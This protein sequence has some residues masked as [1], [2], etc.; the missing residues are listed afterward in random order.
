[1]L[2]TSHPCGREDSDWPNG[3]G[4]VHPQDKKEGLDKL[5]LASLTRESM[6]SLEYPS[7]SIRSNTLILTYII[8]I[9]NPFQYP[10]L[11]FLMNWPLGFWKCLPSQAETI[12]FRDLGSNKARWQQARL[13]TLHSRPHGKHPEIHN[14][15]LF[16]TFTF[17]NGNSVRS[18]AGFLVPSGKT[19]N[20]V[21]FALKD[22]HSVQL[23][24]IL[25]NCTTLISPVQGT[26]AARQEIGIYWW[27]AGHN[28]LFILPNMSTARTPTKSF[29][30]T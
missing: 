27:S 13:A 17:L 24:E 19:T 16:S 5:D 12:L 18:L 29:I 21:P 15:E 22:L 30:G 26:P 28:F 10:L 7:V 8:V 20:L 11:K 4:N 1:M 23:Q 3:L 14:E 9:L 6:L 25:Y 2:P